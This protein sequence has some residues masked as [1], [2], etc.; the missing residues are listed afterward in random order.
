MT[1]YIFVTGGVVSSLGKGIVAA[2][3][4]RL[5]KNRNLKVT[6]QK[7]DP[8]INVDPGTMSPYQHG[9]VFVTDDGTE[10]D[11]DL[12]HYERFI[13][14]NLNKYSNVTT[15]KIYSE[16][17]RKERHGDYL[18]AT[19]QVI[20]HITDAI[21][22]KIM[23]AGKV[24]DSDIVI[25]EIGGTVGD[26]ESLPFLEAIRQMKSEVGPENVVYIH[27][28]LVPYL[29]A[30]REMKTKPTQHSVKELRGLGI[31]PNILVLRTEEPITDS[32]R[33]KIASFCD[34]EPEAVIESRDVASLYEIPLNLQKQKMDDIVLRKLGVEAPAANMDKWHE[35]VDHVQN[36][37]DHTI[38]IALVGKYVALQD[39]YISVN[40]ALKHAGYAVNANV[41]ITN[42]DSEKI[43][44]DNVAE[45]LKGQDGI[46][47]PGG[48][49]DRGIEGM[50]TAIEYA[51]TKNVP[52][53]GVCLGMQMAS[54]EFARNVLGYKD[55]NSTEMN[56]ETPHNVIDL[57][58]DQ[59]GVK[60]MGGTQRL[61]LYPCKLKPGT[62]AAKAYN[63]QEMIQERHRH[64]FEFN[65]QY[66]E[67]MEEKGLVFA[68]TSPDNRLVEVIEIPDKK[69][70]VA[71][72]Y[73]PE[74][75]SRPQRP[76]GLFKAFVAAANL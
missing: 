55:A 26:I 27:T 76:E 47:V 40:E 49:G 8:Y 28:T 75:L 24:T 61:G 9:E 57:M 60:D 62:V 10:T 71:A 46:I 68:G 69:F 22:E 59:E 52:F 29:K 43:N 7:F 2:S 18:G 25:T 15:G 37:L 67:E 36:K 14:I 11:L 20:P 31:Q 17:L 42:F 1:K 53:L 65:N 3:L 21:K 38:N 64:R 23:R 66:R 5:L 33:E 45:V 16:V 63:N 58:A 30:A 73:H 13:D 50:I 48:F 70:F 54:V 32:M 51:R 19:V 4:G 34:V 6:I 72:Q 74:F 35:L 44:P 56:P 39:A 12:G 41:K